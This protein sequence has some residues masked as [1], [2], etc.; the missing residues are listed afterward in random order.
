MATDKVPFNDQCRA[1]WDDGRNEPDGSPALG[2]DHFCMR[3]AGHDGA[4]WDTIRRMGWRVVKSN[5]MP[6]DVA[7]EVLTDV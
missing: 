2:S 5:A 6:R 3:K 4:H 1:N 7:D